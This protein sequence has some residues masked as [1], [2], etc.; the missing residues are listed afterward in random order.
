MM[1]LSVKFWLRINSVSSPYQVRTKSVPRKSQNRVEIDPPR[2][3]IG[4]DKSLPKMRD[5]IADFLENS[6]DR[7]E[8]LTEAHLLV[9]FA[10]MC[11]Y[12][13]FAVSPAFRPFGTLF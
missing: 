5:K 12:L 8:N 3:C 7:R 11:T 2:T 6:C 1:F 9:Q 4:V 13:H 10:S